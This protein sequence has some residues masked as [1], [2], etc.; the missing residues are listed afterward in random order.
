[1][2]VTVQLDFSKF[3]YCNHMILSSP[4]TNVPAC[5]TIWPRFLTVS[6]AVGI[7]GHLVGGFSHW[8]ISQPSYEHVRITCGLVSAQ[9]QQPRL[10][11]HEAV[12]IPMCLGDASRFVVMET[13]NDDLVAISLSLRRATWKESGL[14]GMV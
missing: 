2:R 13:V 14:T 7:M 3:K 10:A 4:Y 1:M 6:E 9:I 8:L 11:N 5:G 12:A